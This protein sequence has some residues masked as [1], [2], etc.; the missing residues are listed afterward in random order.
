MAAEEQSSPPRPPARKTGPLDPDELAAF[1]AQ[2]LTAKLGCLDDDGWPYV[3]P[4][5][6][7]TY[8]GAQEP[9]WGFFVRPLKITSWQGG[10]AKRYK[11]Y[12]W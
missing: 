7:A 10:W 1:L 8:P 4:I 6:Y 9:G 2:P 5:L 12:E 11:S 3:V